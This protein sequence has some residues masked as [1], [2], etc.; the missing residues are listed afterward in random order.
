VARLRAFAAEGAA[1]SGSLLETDGSLE[2]LC[3]K[4]AEDGRGYALRVVDLA[5]EER[6]ATISF[7]TP[8]RLLERCN[9]L[10]APE[11]ACEAP[12]GTLRFRTKPFEVHTFRWEA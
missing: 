10:E 8:P 11:H 7:R 12:D 1:A 3:L 5:G 6:E 4:P 2:L 9:L